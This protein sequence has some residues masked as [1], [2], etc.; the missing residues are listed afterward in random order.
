[1]GMRPYS[2]KYDKEEH[3]YPREMGVVAKLLKFLSGTFCTICTPQPCFAPMDMD[4]ICRKLHIRV[5]WESFV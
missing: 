5:L 4:M 1:M 2:R 3:A